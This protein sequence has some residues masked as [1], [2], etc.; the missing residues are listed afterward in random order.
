MKSF[1]I[2][3]ANILLGIIIGVLIHYLLYRYSIPAKS[4]IYVAF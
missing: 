4:F 1:A 2:K 3:A